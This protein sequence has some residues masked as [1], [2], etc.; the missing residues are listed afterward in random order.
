MWHIGVSVYAIHELYEA[1]YFIIR[2]HKQAAN[3]TG[4]SHCVH[5]DY[6]GQ[7]GQWQI[8]SRPNVNIKTN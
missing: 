5:I 4:K 1:P 8:W 7:A 6:E 2:I 3:E